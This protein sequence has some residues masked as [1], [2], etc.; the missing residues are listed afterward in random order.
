LE[1]WSRCVTIAGRGHRAHSRRSALDK[2]QA[3]WPFAPRTNG[4]YAAV[5][6]VLMVAVT[7]PWLAVFTTAPG[8]GRLLKDPAIERALRQALRMLGY[9]DDL[10]RMPSGV[11]GASLPG[12]SSSW[13]SLLG[14]VLRLRGGS[15]LTPPTSALSVG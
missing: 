4:H 13:R 14:R 7:A 6:P 11:L 3:A 10:D 2:G 15:V 8:L 5:V 1:H 12:A 9:P